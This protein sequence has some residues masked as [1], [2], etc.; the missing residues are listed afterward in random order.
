MKAIV[1]DEPGGPEVL[2]IREIPRPSPQEG[3]VLIKIKAFGLNRSEMYTRQGHSPFVRFPRV[4]GIECVGIVEEA[5]GTSFQAGQPVAA[6]MGGM[7]RKFDGGY[8]EYTC[9]PES[10]VFPLTAD[11]EWAILGA[12]PEMF[13]TAWGSLHAGLEIQPNQTLL[14]RGGT[15][16][17]GMTAIQLAKRFGLTVMAT[18][19]NPDKVEAL[20]NNGAD[21][22]VIDKR[23]IFKSIRQLQPGGVDRVLELVGT[24][25][26]LDSLKCAAPKGIVCMAGILGN[27]WTI[28]NFDPMMMIPP[29][30][31]FTIYGGQAKD[32]NMKALQEFVDDIAKNKIKVNLDRV[33]KFDEIVEAHQYMEDNRACGK[34][35]VLV[36]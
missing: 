19:R 2:K 33:F 28:K 13:Q 6:I 32:I 1:I 15:S 20:K 3:W 29:T 26:L 36:D 24:V 31:K 8:A 27:E 16:S 23:A 30:V 5:P 25:T 7:G 22:V 9:V 12:I 11:L 21:H 35:V 4:L 17:V 14:I 34:L 10:S 18:T